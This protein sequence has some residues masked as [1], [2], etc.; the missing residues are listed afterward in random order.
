MQR[1]AA[2][3]ALMVAGAFGAAGTA[4]QQE[5]S[6]PSSVLRQPLEDAWWTGPILTAGAATLPRG[7]FLIEPPL[8]DV[9]TAHTNGFGSRPYVLY[10]LADRLTVGSIPIMGYNKLS[11]GPSSFGVGLGDAVAQGQGELD[12]G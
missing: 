8:Y 3:A 11:D 6:P 2:V 5:A 12:A 1:C 4:A 7:H 10:G 9:I